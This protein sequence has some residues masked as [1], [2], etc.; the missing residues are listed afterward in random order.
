MEAT[1]PVDIIHREAAGSKHF[2]PRHNV[3]NLF[4]LNAV[5]KRKVKLMKDIST[6]ASV[7]AGPPTQKDPTPPG[8]LSGFAVPD[9]VLRVSPLWRHRLPAGRANEHLPRCFKS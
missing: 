6:S 3:I 2:E 7:V 4:L 8:V 1:L 9:S 5:R